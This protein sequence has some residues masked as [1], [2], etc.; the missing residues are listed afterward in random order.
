MRC[1]FAVIAVC[2]ASVAVAQDRSWPEPTYN[3]VAMRACIGPTLA[4]IADDDPCRAMFFPCETAFGLP[5]SLEPDFGDLTGAAKDDL[6]SCLAGHVH[7]LEDRL[8]PG[9][10]AWINAGDDGAQKMTSAM[11]S[12]SRIWSKCGQQFPGHDL[13]A[14]RQ[15]C[16]QA[17]LALTLPAVAP[18]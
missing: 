8:G 10:V 9:L 12:L 1:A 6:T 5:H 16:E 13:R 17:H 15:A 7:H 14:E 11:R 4:P 2:L 3:V 18:Q